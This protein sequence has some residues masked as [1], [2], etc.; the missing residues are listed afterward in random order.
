MLQAHTTMNP[1]AIRIQ[2]FVP[3]SGSEIGRV[4]I[5]PSGKVG[6]MDQG[7]F[8]SEL[9]E[10]LAGRLV[11]SGMITVRFDIESDRPRGGVSMPA[12]RAKRTKRLSEILDHEAIAARSSPLI[13]LGVSLGA[14]SIV[15]VLSRP[16]SLNICAAVL[17]GCVIEEPSVVMPPVERIDF[18]YGARDL[19]GYRNSDGELSE[20]V[21]PEAYGPRSAEQL[22]VRPR[23]VVTTRIIE[24]VGHTLARPGAHAPDDDTLDFIVN[25]TKYSVFPPSG[26]PVQ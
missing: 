20:V 7:G 6:P 22:I 26:L 1:E 11:S 5:V 4:L 14:L 2:E 23:T 9:Y 24:G 18:V 19:V 8:E 25:L 3:I 15:D 16:T 17:L 13:L 10:R 21:G 12:R